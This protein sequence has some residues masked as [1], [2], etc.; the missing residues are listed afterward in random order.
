MKYNFLKQYNNLKKCNLEKIESIDMLRVVENNY[1]LGVSII[2]G[3]VDNI[4]TKEDLPKVRKLL[5]KD[6]LYKKYK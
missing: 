5:T 6:N 4:D 1:K 3:E 2:K